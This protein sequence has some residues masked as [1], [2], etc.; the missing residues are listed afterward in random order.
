MLELRLPTGRLTRHGRRGLGQQDSRV[1][2]GPRGGTGASA[3]MLGAAAGALCA[4]DN[5]AQADARDEVDH[6]HKLVA[7]AG[8]AAGRVNR[9][10]QQ[11]GSQPEPGSERGGGYTRVCSLPIHLVEEADGGHAVPAGLPPDGLGLR[12]RAGH[13]VHNQHGPVQHAHGPLHLDGEVDVPRSVD[14]RDGG[15]MPAE[16]GGRRLDG[17]AALALLL[18][19]VGHRV[20]RVHLARRAGDARKQQHPLGRRRLTG[21]DVGN[22]PDITGHVASA[23]A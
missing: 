20:A 9:Q 18:Q 13:R 17:D 7:A 16:A 14:Q 11:K 8:G 5:P 1:S 23:A 21:V 4:W 6:A 15:A 19:K 3:A 10:L 12:L 22:D 2:R